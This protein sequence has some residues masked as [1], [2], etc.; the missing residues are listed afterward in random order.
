[1]SDDVN[2]IR[3]PKERLRE[4]KNQIDSL[5]VERDRLTGE[6]ADAHRQMD[7]M[8]AAHASLQE[9]HANLRAHL[10]G[11]LKEVARLTEQVERLGA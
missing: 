10:T 7:A 4:V 3:V 9:E 2:I 8:R 6:L 1:M 5:Q 11:S